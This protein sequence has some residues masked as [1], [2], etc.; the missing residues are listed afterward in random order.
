MRFNHQ[1]ERIT[2]GFISLQKIT[3]FQFLSIDEQIA[4]HGDLNDI[5][6]KSLSLRIKLL[7]GKPVKTCLLEPLSIAT[8][9][10]R[11]WINADVSSLITVF[12]TFFPRA[13]EAAPLATFFLARAITLRRW[14]TTLEWMSELPLLLLLCGL[15]R[16]RV[17]VL[18]LE[19]L[20]QILRQLNN[21]WSVIIP[22][23]QA[24]N[25][26]SLDTEPTKADL[27]SPFWM[28]KINFFLT[29]LMGSVE[30]T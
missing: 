4:L 15:H 1:L 22:F 19:G 28:E 18:L 2:E 24:V 5:L 16:R 14:E 26:A 25:S 20:S 11:E 21:D 9:F 7:K 6:L 10:F 29:P 17:S 13:E 12:I 3:A 23:F 30:I 27:S 8:I